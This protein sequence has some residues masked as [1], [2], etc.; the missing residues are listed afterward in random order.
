MLTRIYIDNFRCFV[1]FEYKPA[2][3]QLI[4]GRNGSGKSSLVDALLL[5]RQFGISGDKF[6]DFYI[7]NQ[8]T[9]WLNQPQQTCELE[10]SL[11][12]ATFIYHLAI[13]PWGDPP[14]PRVLSE[15]VHMDGK[16]IFEFLKGEVHLFND[17]FEHKVT[18]PFDRQRSAFA[19]IVERK[20]NT[21]LSRF[22]SWFGNLFCF[23]LNPF[24]MVARAE[25]EDLFPRVDLSNIAAW[26]RHLLQGNRKQ[27]SALHASLKA[28]LDEFNYLE[29]TAAGE[30]IRLLL[31]DFGGG[32]TNN[33]ANVK[34]AF[35]ELSEGQRCLICLYAVL[36]FLLAK[37]STIIWDEPDNF[38]SLREIQPWL[39]AVSDVVDENKGQILIISHHPELINQ[40]A[41]DFGVFFSRD[42][43]G[44]V[45]L[46]E[47]SGEGYSTLLPSEI[48]AR[49]WENE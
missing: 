19:T 46:K 2:R 41:P 38:I 24:A 7:L 27:D 45:R 17:R 8:R 28:A 43:M 3:K 16:P 44:P 5:L 47:F 35:N 23:R 25:G 22:K 20:D 13:E 42:G 49:G 29:L 33:P 18:Y 36:H 40:W 10:A 34:F 37:G 30:N 12:G 6:D 1:N 4:L 15:T 21:R 39:S 48:V 14:R 11:D 31:A 26:Y 9:R 32:S